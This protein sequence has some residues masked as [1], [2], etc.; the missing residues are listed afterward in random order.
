VDV[1]GIG[2]DCQ[3]EESA[4][5][6]RKTRQQSSTPEPIKEQKVGRPASLPIS[7][8]PP[9]QRASSKQIEERNRAF[10]VYKA[11]VMEAARKEREEAESKEFTQFANYQTRFSNGY[12]EKWREWRWKTVR[13]EKSVEVEVEIESKLR[14][15]IWMRAGPYYYSL[16]LGS[17]AMALESCELE[18]Q[19]PWINDQLLSG[20]ED[21]RAGPYCQ[22]W[23]NG[24]L[25]A[26][27]GMKNSERI[28][29]LLSI[30]SW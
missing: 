3:R 1:D 8:I 12:R 25:D 18:E 20:F 10:R 7:M 30:R 2:G 6:H 13:L 16:L 17:R 29:Q 5:T 24:H 21:L 27:Q 26:V 23:E 15:R 11:K 28:F 19:K 14:L 9:E 4:P 22:S